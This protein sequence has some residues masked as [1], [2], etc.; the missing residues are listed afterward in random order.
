M[1]YSLENLTPW[2]DAWNESVTDS[3]LVSDPLQEIKEL[4]FGQLRQRCVLDEANAKTALKVHR[5][6]KQ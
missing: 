6:Q 2:D 3:N 4:Y 5:I 1:K